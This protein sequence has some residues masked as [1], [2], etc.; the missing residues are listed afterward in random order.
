MK[1]SNEFRVAASLEQAWELLT[2]IE[3]IAPCL[4]GARLT[5]SDGDAYQG[6]MKVKVGPITAEYSGTA[7][8]TEL[9]EAGRRVLLSASGRDSRGAGNASAE[10]EATM[11]EDSSGSG[12][13]TVVSI[14]TEL[15]VAGKVA[16][17]GRGVMADV[18]TKL[19]GQF[20][21]CVEAKL[22][23]VAVAAGSSDDTAGPSAVPA[24]EV[25]DIPP[26]QDESTTGTD[27]ADTRADL[28]DLGSEGTA[29]AAEQDDDNDA[30]DL[31]DVAGAALAKRLVPVA[32]VV[33]VVVVLLVL[34]L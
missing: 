3:A 18:S 8:I 12:H 4:P 21:E 27:R 13:G 30:L 7:T 20:A 16:Q 28:G 23:D 22:A 9:D 11:V 19:I 32:L 1:I 17:F 31:L 2:D 6:T 14:D 26:S 34:L 15:R 33:I 5:G 24:E 10:I 29:S 25:S